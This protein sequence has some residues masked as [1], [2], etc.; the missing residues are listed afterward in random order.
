MDKRKRLARSLEALSYFCF[1]AESQ[2]VAI[3]RNHGSRFRSRAL[4][5]TTRWIFAI[6]IVVASFFVSLWTMNY[7]SP[8]CP[9]GTTLGVRGPFQKFGSSNKA[10][11]APL[12]TLDGISDSSD[13]PIRSD[14]LLCEDNRLLGPA[15]SVHVDIGAKGQGRFSHWKDVGIIFSTTD[16]S[17]PNSNGRQYWVIRPR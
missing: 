6:C 3:L 13:F 4:R 5:S 15:H 7:F 12:P 8:L 11:V 17:D 16:G 14:A 2:S 10:Y 1:E 9:Q